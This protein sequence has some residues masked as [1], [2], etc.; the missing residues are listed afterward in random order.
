MSNGNLD[1][2]RRLRFAINALK[3]KDIDR[4]IRNLTKCCEILECPLHKVRQY[5][6]KSDD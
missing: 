4:A 2:A 3:Y 6:E 5:Q 1:A